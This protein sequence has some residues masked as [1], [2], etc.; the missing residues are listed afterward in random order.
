VVFRNAPDG[1]REAGDNPAAVPV[2]VSSISVLCVPIIGVL[3][4]IIFLGE[5]PSLGEVLALFLVVGAV[6]IVNLPPKR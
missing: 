3:S 1:A 5:R 4:G 2:A 6:L